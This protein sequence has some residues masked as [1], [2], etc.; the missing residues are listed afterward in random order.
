MD[1]NIYYK[2][3][4]ENILCIRSQGK[5]TQTKP[6]FKRDDGFSPQGVPRTA[7]YTRDCHGAEFT[8]SAAEGGLAITARN[9]KYRIMK[10]N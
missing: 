1:V 7:Y 3:V 8:L 2:E 5:Q 10:E 4:Y 6:I 9:M